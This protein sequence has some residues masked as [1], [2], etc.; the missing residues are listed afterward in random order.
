M[1]ESH[2]EAI[3]PARQHRVEEILRAAFAR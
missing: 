1:A 2:G 3:A